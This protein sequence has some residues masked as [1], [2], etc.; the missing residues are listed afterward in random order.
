MDSENSVMELYES[1]TKEEPVKVTIFFGV[2]GALPVSW[3]GCPE[4]K[5]E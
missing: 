1:E 5:E 2:L 3:E 4:G